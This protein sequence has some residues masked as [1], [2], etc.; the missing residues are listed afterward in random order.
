[1][2]NRRCL[3]DLLCLRLIEGRAEAWDMLVEYLQPE[4][5]GVVGR[6]AG[7]NGTV[8][9]DCVQDLTQNAYL[10]LCEEGLNLH[11]SRGRWRSISGRLMSKLKGRVGK[12]VWPMGLIGLRGCD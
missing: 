5:V 3:S 8:S 9:A 2:G 1:M 6:R 12:L 7:R 10:K 11:I 4:I